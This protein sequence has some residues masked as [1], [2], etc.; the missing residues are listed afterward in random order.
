M[1][2]R[3][4]DVKRRVSFTHL[5]MEIAASPRVLLIEIGVVVLLSGIFEN[6]EHNTRKKFARNGS[7]TGAEIMNTLFK[8]ITVLGFVAF[9]IFLVTHT[10]AA[11]V[12][13]PMI[14]KCSTIYTGSHNTLSATFETV[15]MMIFMLLL[16][17]LAQA[18]AMYV[19]SKRI[20]DQW[21]SYERT[22][23]SGNNEQSLE[24]RL[25]QA[26]YL[27]RID[28]RQAPNGVKL[29]QA[30]PFSYG[31]TFLA[32]TFKRWRLLHKIIM[33]RAIRHEF[34]FPSA[35]G[36]QEVRTVPDPSL[37]SFAE[38]LRQ[39][40][41]KVVVS[42]IHVD[43]WTWGM[44]LLLLAPPLYLCQWYPN[45][46]PELV[47]CALVWV[48]F[49]VGLAMCVALERD[50]FRLTPAVPEDGRRIM[51]LFAG[52]SFQMLR[53]EKL[54]G[55]KDRPGMEHLA[56]DPPKLGLP[57]ALT[58][59]T[60][61][62]TSHGFKTWFR[63][64]SFMQAVSVT[65]LLLSHFSDPVTGLA[66]TVFYLLAWLEWPL[67]MFCIVPV[68]V[69]RLTIRTSI[70]QEKDQAII[71]KVTT[72]TKQSLLRDYG[73]LSQL[74]GFEARAVKTK[75]PWTTQDSEAWPRK[76]AI[77]FLLLG[78]KK[79]DKL[80]AIEKREI[81]ALF[82]AWDANAQGIVE[83][84]ELTETFMVMGAKDPDRAIENL[85]RATD[86][87]ET[88]A[89]SWMKFKALFGLATAER[90]LDE[91]REDLEASFEFIDTDS[92]GDLTIFELYE[93]FQRMQIDVG[94][95]DMANLLFLYFG[96]AKPNL[97]KRDFVD[98]IIADRAAATPTPT[99]RDH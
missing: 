60:G 2:F 76:K 32:R 68:I 3:R 58:K 97:G 61:R 22:V 83:A 74:I 37:F 14:F 63:M 30:R 29:E 41:G 26:G 33:W 79:F 80:S 77:Q 78:L 70:Y 51:R 82:A 89:V 48:L 67:F 10:G 56:M 34:L 66:E 85:T 18:A 19:C 71:R 64:L 42:L 93:G 46:L 4:G 24:S 87:D 7:E 8:E 81:W 84:K 15:H 54:P 91:L 92:S 25:V 49:F 13:A 65:S 9:V 99:G 96:E 35:I 53:R 40:L 88:G 5:V 1:P 50:T 16:V 38:Y 47:H 11:D 95:E 12:I 21:G 31:K 98:W 90:P 86:F 28:D 75:E 62:L 57:D 17:L 59:G 45:V 43:R 6:W 27:K 44:T 73:R 36:K 94:L 23:S 72:E 55:W 39:R 20:A 69:R 52:E